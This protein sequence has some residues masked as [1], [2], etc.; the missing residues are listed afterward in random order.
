MTVL[1]RILRSVEDPTTPLSSSSILSALGVRASDSGVQVT[2][3]TS[4]QMAAVWRAVSLIAGTA[5]SLPLKTY[6]QGSR[7]E[8]PIRVLTEPNPAQTA[9]EFWETVYLHM[10]LWGNA[11]VLKERAAGGQVQNLWALHPGRVKVGVVRGEKVFT[12]DGDIDAPF[13]TDRIMHIPGL[14]YDGVTGCSPIRL[15]SQG[16]GL[17]LAAE[18]YGAKLFGSGTLIGGILQTDQRLDEPTADR[19]KLRW[20]EKL[21]GLDNA[22]DVAILDAGAKF[23][24]ITMPNTDAQF[25]ESRRFQIAEIARLFGVPP[26]MLMDSDKST[27]WGTGIEQQSIGFVVYTLRSSWLSRIEQRITKELGPSNVY[28]KYKVE[29]L[30]RGDSA[31]RAA[32]YNVMR[33]VGA[34]SA[35]D[36]LDLEDMPPVDGG[37][38]RLQPLNMAILGSEPGGGDLAD[39]RNLVEMVQKVYLGVGTVLTADE[40][41]ELL[42][43]AGA[44]LAVPS[45]FDDEGDGDEDEDAA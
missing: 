6:R 38:T 10:L 16:V 18:K 19:L 35:N 31:A 13:S 29:G 42:N 4:L 12:I 7:E 8:S 5:A 40:A 24:P 1:G 27:S 36:I 26:H 14:G 9:F 32:F 33:N 41:R 17:S 43:R 15:A 28:A 30:L 45:P 22:H 2:E 34:F 11:Y 20:R 25:I 37:D 23:Q 21:S 39:A 44:G 3:K